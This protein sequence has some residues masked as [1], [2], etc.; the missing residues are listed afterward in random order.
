M[1]CKRHPSEHGAG[2]C[3]P[4]LH[5]RLLI[6]LADQQHSRHHP[7][8]SQSSEKDTTSPPSLRVADDDGGRSSIRRSHR[9]FSLFP[10]VFSSDDSESSSSW[11]SSLIHCRRAKEKRVR[12][13]GPSARGMSP[14]TDGR[15]SEGGGASGSGYSTGSPAGVRRK[16]TPARPTADCRRRRGGAGLAD[17]VV[18]LS[19]LVRPG[20]TGR[21]RRHQAPKAESGFSGELGRNGK[22]VH[23]GPNRSR[24]L[25]DRG[26]FR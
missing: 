4:C 22:P 19:P 11:I 7:S 14:A 24:K 13:Y 21:R 5:D 16:A 2:V 9:R 8:S 18:C 25:A 3:A 26:R 20:P 1:K 17:F 12:S 6:L 23:F 10:S 15:E